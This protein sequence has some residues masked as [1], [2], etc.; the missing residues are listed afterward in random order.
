VIK[1]V[2]WSQREKDKAIKMV[3]DGFT[4]REISAAI[5]RTRNSIIGFIHRSGLSF[6]ATNPTHRPA[7]SLAPRKRFKPQPKPTPEPEILIHFNAVK[8]F[9][10]KRLQCRY[11]LDKPSNVWDTTCCGAPVHK[12]SYC[13]AHHSIVY[14]RP[15]PQPRTQTNVRAN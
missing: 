7:S 9:E 15:T 14:Y 10:A 6:S 11:I 3:K 13:K 8:L 2:I 4:A 5:G 12:L 1:S